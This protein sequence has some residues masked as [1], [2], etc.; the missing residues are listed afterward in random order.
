MMILHAVISNTIIVAVC[1]ECLLI[2]FTVEE[3][4]LENFYCP[5]EYCL[6][7]TD[8]EIYLLK[9]AHFILD[10]IMTI[11]RKVCRAVVN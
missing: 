10:I 8:T 3:V 5:I 7:V 9:A 6:A 1:R 4:F 11:Y 2:N